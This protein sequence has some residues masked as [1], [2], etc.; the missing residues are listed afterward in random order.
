MIFPGK[1]EDDFSRSQDGIEGIPADQSIRFLVQRE[2]FRDTHGTGLLDPLLVA[3]G[4]DQGNGGS[5]TGL[6]FVQPLF[7]E[8]ISFRDLSVFGYLS[9]P[10]DDSQPAPLPG[11]SPG[12]HGDAV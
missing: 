7:Q 1:K 11:P 8:F 4:I 12:S 9:R 2:M 3:F 5:V 6:G 10:G